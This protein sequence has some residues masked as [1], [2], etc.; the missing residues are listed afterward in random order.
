MEH[1][2]D[3]V[4][5]YPCFIPT[6][7]E[8]NPIRLRLAGDE[9]FVLLTDPDLL[10]RFFIHQSACRPDFEARVVQCNNR[11]ILLAALR[12]M[13]RLGESFNVIRVTIDPTP[14][15]MSFV[16]TVQEL[17]EHLETSSD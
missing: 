10:E 3:F 11:A 9:A 5:C 12:L 6:D 4:V 2:S 1:E 8:D 16:A 7:M 17:M 14:G 13:Q 15:R